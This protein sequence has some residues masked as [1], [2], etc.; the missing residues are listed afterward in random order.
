MQFTKLS[1]PLPVSAANP[2][3]QLKAIGTVQV[4]IIWENGRASIFFNACSSPPGLAALIRP[5]SSQDDSSS[6]RPCRFKGSF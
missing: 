1:I 4:P 5:E 3:A 6:H 2:H